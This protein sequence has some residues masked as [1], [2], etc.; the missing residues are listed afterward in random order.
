MS[1]EIKNIL[2]LFLKEK[3]ITASWGISNIRIFPNYL[4]FSVEAMMYKGVIQISPTNNTDC[5]VRLVG[6]SEFQ[7]STK[8]LVSKIDHLI[9]RSDNY[10]TNLLNWFNQ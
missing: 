6:K 1:I 5:I 8:K 9:E 10:Y 4:I 2:L 7:C 3:V